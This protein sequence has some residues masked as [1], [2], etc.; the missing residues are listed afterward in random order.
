MTTIID[1]FAFDRI[2]SSIGLELPLF[3]SGPSEITVQTAAWKA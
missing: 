1:D 3:G 2:T